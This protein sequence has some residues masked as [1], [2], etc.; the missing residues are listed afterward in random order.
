VI[1][2]ALAIVG[3]S[4]VGVAVEHRLGPAALRSA[5]LLLRIVLWVVL[6]VVAFVN[7]NALELDAKVGAGIGYAWFAVLTCMALA[8]GIGRIALRLARPE[9]GALMLAVGLSNTGYLGIPLTAALFGLDDVPHAIAYDVLV[10]AMISVTI[11][12]SIGAAFGTVGSGARERIASFVV[13]N[14]PLWASIAAFLVPHAIA[15]EWVVDA[16][17]VLVLAIVPIGFYA[18]GVTLAATAEDGATAF[19][20]PIDAPIATA[21]AI[22]LLMAPAIVL[23]L[24]ALLLHVPGVYVSQAAMASGITGLAIANAFGLD[25]SLIAAT[26]AWTTMLVLA[27]GLVVALV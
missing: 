25:R 8:Y 13:R 14:P 11:G 5:E 3:S 4:V 16:S 7:L 1:P 18:V 10:N 12:F 21:V 22:K 2:L 23:A 19:P 20:P 26:I 24:S 9:I 6:P 17:Q 27:A 15:P